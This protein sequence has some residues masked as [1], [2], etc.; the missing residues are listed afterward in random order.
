MSTPENWHFEKETV[1]FL[2]DLQANNNREWFQANKTVYE[3]IYKKP[4]DFFAH[5]MAERLSEHFG[6]PF[7]SKV[8]RI[9][10]DVRFSKDKTPYNAHLHIS[11]SPA[12]QKM[13]AFFFGLQ[14][15]SLTLGAGTFGFQ[16]KSL[17]SYRTQV[18]GDAGNELKAIIQQLTDDGFRLS[19]PALKR[20]PRGFPDDH[21]NSD[22]LRY[23]GFAAW[24]DFPTTAAATSGDL[25]ATCLDRFSTLNPL[26]E[27]LLELEN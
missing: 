25:S 26:V 13:P 22:L 23:K 12:G 5:M 24:F 14:P 19:E 8:F 21:A 20:T 4:A 3:E 2:R 9:Y 27:W 18:L 16:G 15:D 10:R 1:R 6:K 17:D 7:T 11:F